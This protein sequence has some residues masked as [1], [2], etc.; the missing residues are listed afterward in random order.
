MLHPH[1]VKTNK[2]GSE[3]GHLTQSLL[4][5]PV[6]CSGMMTVVCVESSVWMWVIAR[7]VGGVGV[8]GVSSSCASVA[9]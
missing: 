1:W 5:T 8:G 7:A 9:G 6:R 4:Q 3:L 2:S